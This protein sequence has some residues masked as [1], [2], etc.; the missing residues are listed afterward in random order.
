[1]RGALR[2][3]QLARCRSRGSSGRRRCASDQEDVVGLE[4]AVNDARVVHRGQP[5]AACCTSAAIQS[6]DSRS[7]RPSTS[8]R[9]SPSSS[10]ITMNGMV[11]PCGAEVDD[12]HHVAVRDR[13]GD[14]RLAQRSSWRSPRVAGISTSTSLSATARSSSM[15]LAR[16]TS[17]IPPEP[18]SS[19]D[20]RPH[21]STAGREGHV[22]FQ[23]IS[24]L[25]QAPK[26]VVHSRC[27]MVGPNEY[28]LL[29]RQR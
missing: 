23:T 28:A 17:P 10:S 24:R 22:A 3:G 13:G 8:A 2:V 19:S 1:M 26:V 20:G 21:R 7:P 12:L 5:R 11:P 27:G 18:I 15:F 9:L 4:I 16:N 6:N 25:A 29:G 14:A